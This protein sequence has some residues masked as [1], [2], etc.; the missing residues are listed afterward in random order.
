MQSQRGGNAI[1]WF[2]EQG[3]NNHWKALS[4]FHS[5]IWRL[6]ELFWLDSNYC[7][8]LQWTSSE[9]RAFGISSSCLLHCHCCEWHPD[10]QKL[11]H[12]T[13]NARFCTNKNCVR[14][15]VILEQRLS[16]RNCNSWGEPRVTVLFLWVVEQKKLLFFRRLSVSGSWVFGY[17][18]YRSYDIN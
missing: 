7:T 5:T 3:K 17:S 2:Q 18:D 1:N 16:D 14:W 12:V 11:G 15:C 6:I 9:K 8:N 10:I 13:V 4:F